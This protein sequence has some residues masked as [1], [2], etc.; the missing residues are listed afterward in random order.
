MLKAGGY[1]RISDR[2][3][4]G[5][6]RDGREGVVRQRADVY[7]LARTKGCTIHRVY[8]DNDTSAFKRR[9]RREGF[10]EMVL[11]LERGVIS[12]MLA[13][14]IDRVA[15]RPQDLERLIDI[16]EQSRRPMLFAT[17]AGDYDLTTADGRF[18]ARIHVTVANKF[19]SDAARRVAR[20]K[21][22]EATEGKPHRG[23]RAFGWK[24]AE[25]IAEGEAAL[26]KKARQDVLTGKSVATVHR[27]WV[28]LGV[29]GPQT[30]PGK[31]IGYSSV[32]YVLRN[33]R[34]CGYRA[35]VP[36]EI[37]ERSGRVDPVEYLVE[38]TDGTPVTG[39]WETILT[40]G[41][42]RELVDELDSRKG[43]EKGRRAGTTV[44]K[45]LL[46]GIAR[47][48]RCGTGLASGMYQRGTASFGKHGYYYY[49]RAADGG[50][51]KLS[52]SGPPLEDHVEKALLDHLMKQARD[53]KS[54][55]AADPGSISSMGT[56]KRIEEDKA[57]ARRLRADGLL[58]L[59]E[60]AREMCRLEKAEKVTRET[61]PAL[62]TPS[63]RP[64]SAAA[65]IVREWN[66]Y[67]V[68]MKRREMGRSI[69][70]VVVAPAG[71]GGAQRGIF[72]PDLIEIVWK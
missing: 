47:C 8:E 53:A 1:V 23:R 13:H 19:S 68:D 48:A 58:S 35:Y 61:V 59:A 4:T 36:Q 32:L 21:L 62:A 49:C 7:D 57:E 18:Q 17:T 38:R 69:E 46:T 33:P 5:D 28:A 51:G 67:T 42:W 9:V 30:P 37:R 64:R 24:D 20:Q 14:D 52:R 70:A 63:A 39:R 60:F 40:P 16:Y 45:R 34:L 55:E 50:C 66:A 15:R 72:R 25:H 12:G 71:K 22:A 41:E 27:E 29:R 56:L 31:T 43:K 6:D 11:D 10:E 44:T 54:A 65:R 2:G 3:R 26:I